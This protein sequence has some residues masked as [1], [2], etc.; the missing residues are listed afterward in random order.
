MQL[1]KSLKD[2]Q[3]MKESLASE[4]EKYKACDPETLKELRTFLFI[5]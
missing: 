2:K 3:S 1:L 5:F 4:L